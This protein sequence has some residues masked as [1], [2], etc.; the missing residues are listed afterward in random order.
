M[1]IIIIIKQLEKGLAESIEQLEPGLWPMRPFV[2]RPRGRLPFSP[3]FQTLTVLF[4]PCAAT[5]FGS[6]FPLAS[7]SRSA[8]VLECLLPRGRRGCAR[9]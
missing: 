6:F 7:T 5:P 8:A 4:L 2:G 3:P 9:R 1:K